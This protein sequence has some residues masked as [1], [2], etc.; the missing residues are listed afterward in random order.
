MARPKLASPDQPPFIWGVLRLY[1]FAASLKLAVILLFGMALTLGIA[2]AVE[3]AFN[4]NV[5]QFYVYQSW[6]FSLLYLLLAVNI[7]CAAA[8]RFPWKRHQTGFVITHIGLLTL[9]FSGVVSR[10]WR[11]DS[12]VSVWEN[13]ISDIRAFEP[14]QYRFSLRI[15][16]QGESPLDPPEITEVDIPFKPGPFSWADYQ[17]GFRNIAVARPEVANL[18]SP[19]FYLAD[20][21]GQG[22]VLYEE[23]DIRLE[24]LDYYGNSHWEDGV[25]AVELRLSMPAGRKQAAD[26]RLVTADMQWAPVKLGVH[27]VEGDTQYKYG[28]GDRQA[29]GAG[30]FTMAMAPTRAATVAFLEGGPNGEIGEKGT[31]VLFADGKRFDIDVAEAIDQESRPL[32]GTKF[33]YRLTSYLPSAVPSRKPGGGIRWGEG[34]ASEVPQNP[35]VQIELTEGDAPVGELVLLADMPNFNAQAFDAEVYGS[36]WF[37]HGERSSAELLQGGG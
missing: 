24:V 16:R 2:T 22:D 6:W 1:E 33:S 21:H 13:N 31:V 28:V 36:Y 3:A 8:I 5:V 26:G 7:F 20:R 12:Q 9:M 35:A 34:E 4:T 25:P 14:D 19:L 15:D 11:I 37:N 32:D 23:G 10:V 27:S 30:S 18:F 29:M 17:E